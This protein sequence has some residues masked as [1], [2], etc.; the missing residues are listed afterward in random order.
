MPPAAGY[1]RRR[2]PRRNPLDPSTTPYVVISYLAGIATVY[3]VN[4]FRR[5][6]RRTPE[7]RRQTAPPSHVR[8]LERG[9]DRAAS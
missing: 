7:K 6:H 1:G 3:G 2:S 9:S 8:L 5:H 4:Y